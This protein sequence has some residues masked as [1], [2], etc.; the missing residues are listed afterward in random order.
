MIESRTYHRCTKLST[1]RDLL[2]TVTHKHRS[3]WYMFPPQSPLNAPI[4]RFCYSLSSLPL[5]L[6]LS[7]QFLSMLLLSAKF[8]FVK[9]DSKLIHLYILQTYLVHNWEQFGLIKL[10]AIKLYMNIC[11]LYMHL[12]DNKR[13]DIIFKS[14]YIIKLSQRVRS[15]I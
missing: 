12:N 7:H 3:P 6:L 8:C 2:D 14:F 13:Y 9:N 1:F 4:N 15:V 5:P 10:V 11:I